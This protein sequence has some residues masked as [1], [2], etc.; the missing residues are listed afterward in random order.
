MNS[1]PTRQFRFIHKMPCYFDDVTEKIFGSGELALFL[2]LLTCILN[3]TAFLWEMSCHPQIKRSFIYYNLMSANVRWLRMA[4]YSCFHTHPD[5][6]VHF[7]QDLVILK[8]HPCLEVCGSSLATDRF[9]LWKNMCSINL[10]QIHD[11]LF[12]CNKQ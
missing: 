11:N 7:N 1:T 12:L 6:F 4:I 3:L 8:K 9:L 10:L 5:T 2:L